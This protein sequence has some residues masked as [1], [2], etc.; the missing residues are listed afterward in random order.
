MQIKTEAMSIFPKTSTAETKLPV[1][2]IRP[3]TITHA[4]GMHT[5]L[6]NGNT[7]LEH[8]MKTQYVPNAMHLRPPDKTCKLK[9]HKI[10]A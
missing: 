8:D 10:K 6:K 4:I 2:I 5:N 9:P 7:I 3:N 1:T